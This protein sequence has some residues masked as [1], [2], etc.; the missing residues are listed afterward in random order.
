M[1]QMVC[2]IGSIARSVRQQLRQMQRRA[3]RQ[4]AVVVVD[5]VRIA[6]VDPLVIR[7]VGV[8]RVDAHALGDD[9]VQRPAGTHQIVKHLAGADLVARHDALFQRGIELAAS[10][11]PVACMSIAV[12]SPGALLG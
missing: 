8:G 1:Y 4:Q 2:A 10:P 3:R 11:P 12:C 9:L 7:H 5:E 6:V